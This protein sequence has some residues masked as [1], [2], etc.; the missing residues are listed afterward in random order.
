MGLNDQSLL[1]FIGIAVLM[2]I[3]VVIDVKT[4]RIPN[5]LTV[6]AFVTGIA[7]HVITNGWQG[8]GFSMAGFGVG[9][10]ILLVLGSPAAAVEAMSSSW[11]PW[12]LGLDRCVRF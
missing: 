11:E 1:P 3:A 12:A 9:F 2:T 6:S 10:G 8:L 5:W 4:R 7:Y